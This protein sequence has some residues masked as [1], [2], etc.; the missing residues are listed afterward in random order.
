MT[1]TLTTT[2]TTNNYFYLTTTNLYFTPH[3]YSFFCTF[4][5]VHQNEFRLRRKI[6]IIFY[7]V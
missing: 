2:T 3:Y 4:T 5:K 6:F 1:L 7:F